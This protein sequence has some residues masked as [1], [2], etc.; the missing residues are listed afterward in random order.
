M[1]GGVGGI[2]ANADCARGV[3]ERSGSRSRKN[4]FAASSSSPGRSAVGLLTSPAL[5]MTV[6]TVMGLLEPNWLTGSLSTC[7]TYQQ[8]KS[9]K[10]PQYVKAQSLIPRK[11]LLVLESYSGFTVS[12]FRTDHA[13]WTKDYTQARLTF[14]PCEGPAET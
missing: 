5:D 6:I 9:L 10:Q 7:L 1:G 11:R 13:L 2:A 4:R 3:R 14:R 8:L 12:P